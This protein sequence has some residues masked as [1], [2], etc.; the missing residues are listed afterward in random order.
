MEYWNTSYARSSGGG[1]S[2]VV[3]ASSSRVWLGELSGGETSEPA[4]AV[5]AEAGVFQ[6]KVS[7]R[8][9][10]G[11]TVTALVSPCVFVVHLEC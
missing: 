5:T 7:A 2:T 1:S 11:V 4:S 3:D 10:R 6:A 9:N 8:E